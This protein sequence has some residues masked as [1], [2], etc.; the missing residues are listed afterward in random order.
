MPQ[1]KDCY[2]KISKTELYLLIYDAYFILNDCSVELKETICESL[3][4]KFLD[5][6]EMINDTN[7]IHTSFKQENFV[8]QECAYTM[9]FF[10]NES[11]RF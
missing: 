3:I 2:Y 1:L 6:R 5:S 4:N 7:L 8:E 11:E 9:N 10:G